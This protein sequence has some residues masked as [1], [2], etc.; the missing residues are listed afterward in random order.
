ME[1]LLNKLLEKG[2]KPRGIPHLKNAYYTTKYISFSKKTIFWL[3]FYEKS[4]R[5][6]VAKES[7]LW[8]FVCENKIIEQW[9]TVHDFVMKHICYADEKRCWWFSMCN[10]EYYIMMCSLLEESELEEFLLENIKV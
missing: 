7:W 9:K 6:L 4:I 2:W 10:A 1:K 8:Q 5:A 3:T